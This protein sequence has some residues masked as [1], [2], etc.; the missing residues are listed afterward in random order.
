M[1]EIVEVLDTTQFQA[2]LDKISQEQEFVVVYI[3]G[4]VDPVTG[5]NWCP[6]CERAKPN[7][8]N[9]L[10]A[11]TTG[12]VMKCIVQ[13]SEWSGRA[14]HPYKQSP[15]LKARGVPTVLLIR[16][17][18]VVMRAEKDEDFDNEDLLLMIAKHE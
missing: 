4:T 10:L 11:N 1:A 8:T 9:I 2:T 7:I 16:E 18:E 3:T 6:D 17:G 5:T 15:L 14:D 13:R 12:K